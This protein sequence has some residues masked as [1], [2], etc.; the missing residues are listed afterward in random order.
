MLLDGALLALIALWTRSPGYAT[1]GLLCLLLAGAVVLLWRR[2]RRLQAEVAA[3]REAVRDEAR[4][5]RDLLK[6]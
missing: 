2:Q 4:A 3:A 1:G 6:S 5:L